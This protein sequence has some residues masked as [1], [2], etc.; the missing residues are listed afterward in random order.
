MFP[1]T[2]FVAYYTK[3]RGKSN[4]QSHDASDCQICYEMDNKVVSN[5]KC[6][7]VMPYV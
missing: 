1:K 5:Y 7:F 3:K 2:L 6:M 4:F